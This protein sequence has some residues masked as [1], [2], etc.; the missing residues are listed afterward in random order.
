MLK[1]TDRQTGHCNREDWITN[2]LARST[3]LRTRATQTAAS[4]EPNHMTFYPLK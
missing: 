1:P 2:Q 3:Q 4:I